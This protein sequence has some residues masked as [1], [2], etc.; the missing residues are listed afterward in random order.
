[1]VPQNSLVNLGE[2]FK[3]EA[4]SPSPS[5]VARALLSDRTHVDSIYLF[6]AT[7]IVLVLFGSVTV[8]FSSH[9]TTSKGYSALVNFG[10]FFYASFLKPHSKNDKHRGQQAALESFYNAQVGHAALQSHK[11]SGSNGTT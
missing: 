11:I 2:T 1:M 7:S 6:L 10:K 9:R 3:D 8:A 5:A 4:M